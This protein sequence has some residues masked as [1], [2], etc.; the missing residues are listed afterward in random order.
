MKKIALAFGVLLFSF[1]I[2]PLT[3]AE[4]TA[5]SVSVF[6]DENS[7][8][9]SSAVSKDDEWEILSVVQCGGLDDGRESIYLLAKNKWWSKSINLLNFKQQ[10]WSVPSVCYNYQND[11]FLVYFANWTPNSDA[12]GL[13]EYTKSNGQYSKYKFNRLK[14]DYSEMGQLVSNKYGCYLV[15]LFGEYNPAGDTRECKIQK[16]ISANNRLSIEEIPA[17]KDISVS[18]ICWRVTDEQPSNKNTYREVVYTTED[19]IIFL[20]ANLKDWWYYNCID[21]TVKKFDSK[22]A[23]LTYKKFELTLWQLALSISIL[24]SLILVFLLIYIYKKN[25]SPNRVITVADLDT[26]EKNR[27]IFNIQ[28]T[29]RSKISRDIHD[30]IIQDIRVIRLQTE[31]LEVTETSVANQHKIEDIATDC[32]VKLRNIC[33]NLT[34][35]ELINHTDGVSSQ[36]ELVSIITSLAK[37]FSNRTHV[38]CTVGVAPDFEYPILER[39]TTQNLF[40]VVQEA[41]TNVEKHSYAKKVNIYLNR[42]EKN[43]VIYITDDGVGCNPEK[44]KEKMLSKE[45]LG[46]RSMKDRMSLIGG[47]IE[48]NSNQ[49]DGM[50]VRLQLEVYK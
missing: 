43:L 19:S 49:D 22:E 36:L 3:G 47:E 20:D 48:F 13:Y 6:L 50:E 14:M 8:I 16:V 7:V 28:E 44:L 39:E 29:E 24:F 41:L 46:L 15:S 31:N 23:A 12:G 26:K 37:Q 35:A 21:E 40:R 17:L 1:V 30:S 27:F 32:I 42:K 5:S 34:P 33:Y 9:H 11:S 2:N 4:K 10:G 45:H 18:H 25:R 38:P